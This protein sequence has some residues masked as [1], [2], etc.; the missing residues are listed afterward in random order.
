MR[1]PIRILIADD[2][3]I[4]RSGL[5]ALLKEEDD[6]EI[7]GETGNG[8]DTLREVDRLDVD[9]LLLDLSMPGLSGSQVAEALLDQDPHLAIVVLT[10]H[11]EE[12]YLRELFKMGV[13]GFILKK[14][15]GTDLIQAIRT[16][17]RG[18]EY[19]DPSMAGRFVALSVGA[20]ARRR[21]A[22]D[23]RLTRREKEVCRL[24]ALG[25]TNAE[26]AEQLVISE[27]TVE[28]HRANLMAKLELR[29]RAEL[30]RY[31]I[32]HGLMSLE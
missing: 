4:F 11:E 26:V 12:Y 32:D 1:R 15:T 20:P 19:V 14:S 18:G 7:V 8:F 9:L 21:V 13:R 24:L 28:T 17:H 29:T 25:N 27:R 6:F 22:Q 31:A 30:V 3:A 16:V 10:M 2:H 23:E 5:R